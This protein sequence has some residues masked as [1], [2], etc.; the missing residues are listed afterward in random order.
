MNRSG[1]GFTLETS[2]DDVKL[3]SKRVEKLTNYTRNEWRRCHLSFFGVSSLLCCCC[4]CSSF[5]FLLWHMA[6]YLSMSL[7]AV[8]F[9]TPTHLLHSKRVW[10]H[11]FPTRNECSFTSSPLKT[12]VVFTSPPLVSSLVS[13]WLGR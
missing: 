10:F 12:S 5:L 8:E 1:C 11:I 13:T 6:S 2:G 3:H 4:F 9:K 7:A